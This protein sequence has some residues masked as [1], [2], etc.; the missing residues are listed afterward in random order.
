MWNIS[1]YKEYILSVFLLFS[2]TTKHLHGFR[3]LPLATLPRLIS[4][5]APIVVLPGEELKDYALDV[6]NVIQDATLPTKPEEVIAIFISEATAGFTG[7]IL[8]RVAAYAV[9]DKAGFESN[10]RGTS[11]GA[12]FAI[13]GALR[14]ATRL[15][16]LSVPVSRLVAG[17]GASIVAESLK[18]LDYNIKN[19]MKNA[20]ESSGSNA[21]VNTSYY[22]VDSLEEED[23]KSNNKVR[24]MK[25]PVQDV[26][27]DIT[28]WIAYDL[29]LPEDVGDHVPILSA[30]KYGA[31]AGIISHV[32]YDS[33]KFRKLSEIDM[34]LAVKEF[35]Q[36]AVEAGILF[37]SYESSLP[38]I[39]TY[40]TPELRKILLQ[41][42][43]SLNLDLFN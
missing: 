31:L 24:R 21:L 36:A 1:K 34:K 5:T 10:L 13:R 22:K 37:A 14:S 11:T 32:V 16:G 6:L 25:L 41:D 15:A 28:K 38:L 33:V 23:E 8:E 9:G 27:Q 39:E 20:Q 43:S 30:L 4:P 19:N 42:F 7:G 3:H 12:Y 18:A 26:F 40:A 2:F 17:V 29:L 35:L